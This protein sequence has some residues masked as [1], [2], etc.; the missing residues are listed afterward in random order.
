[1][2]GTARWTRELEASIRNVDLV[3]DLR[4]ERGAQL[5]IEAYRADDLRPISKTRDRTELGSSARC[6]DPE[7]TLLRIELGESGDPN[8][9]V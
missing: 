6:N 8:L 4:S 3:N 1:M 5:D 9:R 7:A 2:D